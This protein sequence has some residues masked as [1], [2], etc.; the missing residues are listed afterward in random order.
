MAQGFPG[1]AQ[2]LFGGA[3]LT[4][5]RSTLR[6]W[7]DPGSAMQRCAPHRVREK[8]SPK[9]LKESTRRN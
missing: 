9:W 1:A 6:V 5:D 8:H 2:H 7:N 3:L 4:R